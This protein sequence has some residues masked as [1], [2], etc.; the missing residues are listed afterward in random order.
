MSGAY[1]RTL[2]VGRSVVLHVAFATDRRNVSDYSVI[3]TVVEEGRRHTNEMHR[4]TLAGG[5]QP[6]ELFHAGT[7]GEGMRAAIEEC[8]LRYDQIIEAWKR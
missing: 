1:E 5:K 7:L 8:D 6:G 4:Y 3:L 2:E